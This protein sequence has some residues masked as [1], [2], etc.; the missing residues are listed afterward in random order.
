[1]HWTSVFSAYGNREFCIAF[2]PVG[3]YR[4]KCPM[5]LSFSVSDVSSGIGRRVRSKMATRKYNG[6]SLITRPLGLSRR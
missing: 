1:M 4:P 2:P 3:V 5:L 6:I